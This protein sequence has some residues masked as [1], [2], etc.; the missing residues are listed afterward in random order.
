MVGFHDLN[1]LWLIVYQKKPFF[2]STHFTAPTTQVDSLPQKLSEFP[3]WGSDATLWC[4]LISTQGQN[5][6]N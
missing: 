6:E 2:A 4:D 1:N 5:L 3:I